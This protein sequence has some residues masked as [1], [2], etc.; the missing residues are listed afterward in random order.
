[1]EVR[2]FGHSGQDLLT[3]S[4]S[5]FDPLRKSAPSNLDDMTTKDRSVLASKLSVF[6]RVGLASLPTPLE[7]MRRL[8]RIWAGHAY[9]GEA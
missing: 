8:R 3:L 1:M 4:S 5:Y 6:P 9:V 2:L 7:P